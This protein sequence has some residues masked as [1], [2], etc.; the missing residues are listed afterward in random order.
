MKAYEKGELI[1][2][3]DEMLKQE[4]IFSREKVYHRGWFCSWPI[5]FAQG[6]I[7]EKQIFKAIKTGK[8]R[9]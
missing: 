4:F 3:L 1:T 8:T 6:K 9:V 7:Q 5:I 2:S